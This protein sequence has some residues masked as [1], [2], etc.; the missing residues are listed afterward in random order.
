LSDEK[1]YDRSQ[2]FAL[3]KSVDN[4]FY[5]LSE[6]TELI[7]EKQKDKDGKLIYLYTNSLDTQ[8]MYVSKA[9]EKGYK[10][11]V[12]DSPIVSHVIQKLES[13][14]DKS[15]FVRVDSDIIDNLIKKDEKVESVLSDKDQKKLKPLFEKVLPKEGFVVGFE[16]LSPTSL[17]VSITQAEFMRRMKEMSLTG[18]GGPMMGMGN[19]PDS[20]NVVINTNHAL[21]NKINSLKG[22]KKS[23][24]IQQSI[25]LALLSQNLLKGEKLTQYID[26]CFDQLGD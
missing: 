9:Q 25:N 23:V 22:K 14:L 7:K 3:Y 6:F 10:V 1:F 12:L 21:I 15:S 24:L 20:Y 5:T 17:P 19:M 13:K 16:S 4:T 26:N 11:L 18:G 8:H 2:E